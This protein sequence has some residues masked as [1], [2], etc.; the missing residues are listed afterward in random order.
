MLKL[1]EVGSSLS[2]VCL[3]WAGIHEYKGKEEGG[4]GA[5][6]GEAGEEWEGWGVA[7]PSPHPPPRPR[8]YFAL[9]R[10]WQPSCC[11]VCAVLEFLLCIR[12]LVL[13]CDEITDCGVQ[14]HRCDLGGETSLLDACFGKP[15][16][17]F[18]QGLVPSCLP[19]LGLTDKPWAVYWP[20]PSP[21]K[22]SL[23]G[24]CP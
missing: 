17:P 6:A 22:V 23:H 3:E 20:L 7:P 11:L 18:C 12:N 15:P 9:A 24:L 5:L 21:R 16:R 19:D 10:G 13:A 1:L 8:P 4:E 14:P 2:N